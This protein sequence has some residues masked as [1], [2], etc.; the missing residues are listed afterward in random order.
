MDHVVGHGD[1]FLSHA[2]E[3]ELE[4]AV[5]K[6]RD[7]PY[8]AGRGR[9]WVKTKCLKRQEFVVLGYTEPQGART[10]FGALLL[11]VH[12]DDGRLRYAGRVGTGFTD[13][14]LR[15]LGTLLRERASDDAADRPCARRRTR[16]RGALGRAE[17]RRRGHGSPSG[18]PRAR[19]GTPP[20]SDCARTSPPR[21]S[22]SRSRP[23]RPRP[24]R[25]PPTRR[26]PAPTPVVAGVRLTNPDRVFWPEAAFT[27]LDLARYLEAVAEPMLAHVADRPLS[28]VRCPS[29]YTGEC[30][31]QK[32]VENF[33][34]SVGTVAVLEPREGTTLPYAVVSDLAG[35]VG[36]AQMGVLE[37]HP[38]GSRADDIERPDRHRVRPRSR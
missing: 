26:Q 28:L 9:D 38:W 29:G 21:T 23:R 13:T 8:R 17:A 25:S 12:D 30:F 36:L 6:R 15:D 5:S 24:I 11:G 10:D 1:T 19:C 37:I 3:L 33:P 22:W 20:S 32:H 14:A 16:S 31:Y 7:A 18:P 2:C 4:G 34:S 35:L 27:K